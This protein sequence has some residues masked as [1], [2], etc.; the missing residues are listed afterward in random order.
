[1][2]SA[3]LGAGIGYFASQIA[4]S[5]WEDDQGGTKVHRGR[6]AAAAGAGAFAIGFSFPVWGHAPG[7]GSPDPGPDR[8]VITGEEIRGASIADALEAVEHFHPEWLVERGRDAFA[9]PGADPLSVYLDE[10]P[11]GETDALQGISSLMIDYIRFL[12]ARQATARWGTGHSH[13]VIQ[14]ITLG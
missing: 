9:E 12:D 4:S 7:S 6:W 10:V 3:T 13:G 1:L 8:F 11:L 2:A 5:D 14:V